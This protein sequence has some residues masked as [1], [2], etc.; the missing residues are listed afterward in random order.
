M[1]EDRRV[2]L[3]LLA[4]NSPL[5][6]QPASQPHRLRKLASL[7]PHHHGLDP[8]RQLR[9]APDHEVKKKKESDHHVASMALS[10]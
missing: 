9:P 3:Q 1:S 2:Y 7:T 6:Q 5:S 4:F 10:E 8:P